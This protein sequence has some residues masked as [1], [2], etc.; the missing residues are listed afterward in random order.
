MH[1]KEVSV[2]DV[3]VDLTEENIDSLMSDWTAY[4]KADSVVLRNG[5]EYAI[6]EI[7]KEPGVELFRRV[8][9]YRIVALPKDTVFVEDPTADVTNIP[10]MAAI[11]YRNPGKAV[12]VR[13][14]FSHVNYTAGV[15]P[16]VLRVIDNVPPSPSKLGVLVRRALGSGFVN[17]P[18]VVDE[19]VI[20]MVSM[21]KDVRTEAVMFPCA[22]SD[23]HSDMPVY[24]LDHHPELHHEVTLI[25]CNLSKRIFESLYGKDIPFI[26]VCPSDEADG[27]VK[28]IV[29]CCKV[30]EGY[31]IKGNIARVPWGATVPEVVA[32][33]NALF[34]DE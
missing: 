29:K 12:V 7:S 8:E 5:D 14:L 25:G 17:L 19:K 33:I 31:E 24:Y 15:K 4:T 6:V 18:V 30:K 34:L 26:D 13:G 28:T 27:S 2:T 32:A 22:V 1:C 21:I 11:Q 16:L 10:A 23:V 9:S 3:D 20:D